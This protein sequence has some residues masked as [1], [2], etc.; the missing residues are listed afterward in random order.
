M[1]EWIKIEDETP[2]MDEKCLAYWS[3]SKHVEDVIFFW[4]DGLC[5]VLFDGEILNDFPSHWMWAP[6][7]PS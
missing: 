6:K 1:S 4:D 5:Y 2:P 7:D 3:A